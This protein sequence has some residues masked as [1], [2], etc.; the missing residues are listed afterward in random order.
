MFR[1]VKID[2]QGNEETLKTYEDNQKDGII[3]NLIAY[4]NMYEQGIKKGL[5]KVYIEMKI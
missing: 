1:I 2:N 5:C 3:N 4:T